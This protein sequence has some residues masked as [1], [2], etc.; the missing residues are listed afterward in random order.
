MKTINIG[1]LGL[2]TVGSGVVRIL[3]ENQN[4]ISNV[5]DCNLVAKKI[6][7]HDLNKKRNLDLNG[8]TLT[9]DDNEVINDPDIQ[10]IVEVMGT[11]EQAK[12]N[13]EKSL[14]AGKHVI[15][16]NKDLMATHGPALA[17]LAQENNR[18][19]F[20]EASV[21]GGIPILR[22]IANS[23][24]ADK[25]VEVIGIVNGTTNYI[26]TQMNEH[27]LSYETALKDAQDLGFAESDPTNDVEGIDAAY[28]MIILT[29][30][31]FG[32]NV[33]LDD[34][35]IK[36]I[37][38]IKANDIK[39]AKELGYNIK[40]LGITKLINNHINVSVSPVLVPN[41]HPL[42][43]VQNE[44]N[45]VFVTGEAVGE[46]MF[47]GPGAGALPTANS[48]VSDIMAAAKNI[49]SNTSGDSFNSYS[50]SGTL[51]TPN[52]VQYPYYLSLKIKDQP[53]QMMKITEIMTK[54]QASFRLILQKELE[55]GYASVVMTTHEISEVQLNQIIKEVNEIPGV[56]VDTSYKV[57]DK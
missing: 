51:A 55:K 44:N 30:F 18:D 36:G 17:K 37:S 20:Y 23:F 21:A 42:A 56:Q 19:L 50:Q 41:R 4:K 48:V 39:Q 7:V 49:V 5:T 26:M 46:T 38:S 8:I 40:L 33:T 29:K 10:I 22:T 32:I 12:Q 34:V 14:K 15:T 27:Q 47:Y 53:G 2:G 43:S 52:E 31:A 11:V 45:A 1:I 57:L 16:A 9:N 35:E 24:V 13:I 54:V 3:K 25:V 6:A 28:K